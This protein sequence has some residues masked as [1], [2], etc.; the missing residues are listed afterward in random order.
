MSRPVRVLTALW[1]GLPDLLFGSI[2]RG[3]CLALA[4]AGLAD[5]AV[6]GTWLWW[7]AGRTWGVA[8]WGLAGLVW[9][10]A[11]AGSWRWVVQGMP[12][13]RE[14]VDALFRQAQQHQLKGEVEAAVG[15]LE[16]VLRL[17]P[18]DI[19]AMVYLAGL[20]ERRGDRRTA[21]GWWRRCRV[22]DWHDKWRWE[23][24][25]GIERLKAK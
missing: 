17:Q 10:A 24:E 14:E 6:A 3:L 5:L 8:G 16:Q 23:A 11:A 21:L 4:F 22:H 7:D 13:R 1:P 9:I 2:G 15:A 20:Y 19:D 12:D 18:A 25:R